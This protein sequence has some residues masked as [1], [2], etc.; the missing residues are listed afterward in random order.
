MT[1]KTGWICPKCAKV[2][3]PL[4]S[5]CHSCNQA[6]SP[7]RAVPGEWRPSPPLFAPTVWN[8]GTYFEHNPYVA[9]WRMIGCA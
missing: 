1:D 7:Q 5:E 4:I 8:V 6:L 9:S 3:G 2:Y